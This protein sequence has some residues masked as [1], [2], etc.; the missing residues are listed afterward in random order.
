MDAVGLHEL[1]VQRHLVE[2]KRYEHELVLLCQ[3]RE[4]VAELLAV[5]W[6]VVRRYH[7]ADEHHTRSRCTRELDGALEV[8]S[9]RGQ[10]QTAQPVIAAELDDHDVGLVRFEYARQA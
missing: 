4:H 8:L 2:Q 10:W 5:T 1:R 9:A 6:S 7:H 3:A